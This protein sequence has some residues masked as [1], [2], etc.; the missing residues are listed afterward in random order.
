MTLEN[1]AHAIVNV[2]K[3]RPHIVTVIGK[4]GVGK[5]TVSIMI[6][7]ILSKK[8]KVLLVSLDQAMHLLKYLSLR[9]AHVVERVD[10][11]LYAIQFDLETE[12]RKFTGEYSLLLRQI[13]P[14]LKVL[15]VEKVTDVVRN[16]PGFEEEV[17]L[18]FLSKL[19]DDDRYDYIV[20]DTPPTGVT[21]RILNLP[22]MY[23]FWL[24][25]LIE[26]RERIVGLRYAIQRVIRGRAEM[27]DEVL[28][29]LYEMKENY[30]KLAG[31]ITDQGRTSYILV[32]TPEPLPVYEV[33]KTI[34]VLRE[35]GTEPVGIVVNKVIPWELAGK[36]GIS[37]VQLESIMDV[38]AIKCR[39][40]T[41][42]KIAIL[43]NERPPDTLEKAR[44]AMVKT[45]P[46][47]ATI[48][49]GYRSQSSG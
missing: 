42:I 4:G 33:K 40:S 19:Y 36:M 18:R 47:S 39:T 43:M 29:K 20:I 16:S 8:G 26:L 45:I 32:A 25:N 1:L 10:G 30:V 31:M 2:A 24:D 12:A 27:R 13:M 34:N 7:D 21:L 17:Y 41:C 3:G 15:N 11:E 37:G 38:D 5:T 48:K 6:A 9:R 44:E 35:L 22:R 23:M 46:L 28:D 14:G 49:H